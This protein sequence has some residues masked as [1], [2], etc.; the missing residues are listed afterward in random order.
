VILWSEPTNTVYAMVHEAGKSVHLGKP[1]PA[2]AKELGA[3]WRKEWRSQPQ[4]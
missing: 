1:S 2:V 4:D 3:L